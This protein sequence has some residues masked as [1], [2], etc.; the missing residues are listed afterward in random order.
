MNWG[1][2]FGASLLAADST[3]SIERTNPFSEADQPSTPDTKSG[4]VVV[5]DEPPD[6]TNAK[7][8]P[9]SELGDGNKC[10]G[11]L[12]LHASVLLVVHPQQED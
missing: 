6:L 4:E 11:G 8:R 7:A 1:D 9:G 10:G 2:S 3:E 5:T 12:Q